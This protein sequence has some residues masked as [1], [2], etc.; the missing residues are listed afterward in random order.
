MPE[1]RDHNP[2]DGGDNKVIVAM[3]AEFRAWAEHLRAHLEAD[4]RYMGV[5]RKHGGQISLSAIFKLAARLGL[6]QM[7]REYKDPF[8]PEKSSAHDRD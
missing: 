8:R 5:L 6:E 4:T 2:P 1:A 3:P 7:E